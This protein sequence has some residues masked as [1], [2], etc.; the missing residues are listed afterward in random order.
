MDD[1][2]L[3]SVIMPFYK[4]TLYIKDTVESILKQTYQ[5]F[6][7]IIINDE[8]NNITI[9]FLY[10]ISKLDKRIK[11]LNNEKNIGAGESRN[12]GIKFSKGNYIAFCDSDDLWK[13][14]KLKLQLDFMKESELDFSFTSYEVI[15]ENNKFITTRKAKKNINFFQL[16]NSCDIGLSTV[17]LKAKIFDNSDFKFA[18]LKT[19]EDY[20]LWLNLSKNSIKMMGL[21]QTLASWR[22]SHD[23]L[24]SS[25]YQKIMDGYKVYRDYL[26]YGILRSLFY[27]IIL[28]IN[29]LFKN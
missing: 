26:K 20:V 1:M 23:S 19:K 14:N 15:D 28:S 11:I 9:D 12:K 13:E 3:V 5:N 22:K 10:E 2:Y 21:D 6:E 16:R 24:S 29:K 18:S 25:S 7:I 27:L 17:M 8:P 4:K